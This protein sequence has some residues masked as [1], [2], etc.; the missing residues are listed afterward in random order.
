MSGVAAR[1]A[2]LDT[3]GKIGVVTP[4]WMGWTGLLKLKWVSSA[5]MFAGCAPDAFRCMALAMV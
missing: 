3:P 4:G 1:L 2:F 5:A